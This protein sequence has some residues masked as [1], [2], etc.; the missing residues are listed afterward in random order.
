MNCQACGSANPDDAYFC[1]SCGAQMRSAMERGSGPVDLAAIGAQDP[2]LLGPATAGSDGG[3]TFT[4]PA[5][6]DYSDVAGTIAAPPG[7]QPAAPIEPEAA[8]P[9]AGGYAP[10]PQAGFA[11][12][13]G[14]YAAPHYPPAQYGQPQ[15]GQPAQYG[16]PYAPPPYGLPADGNTS[17]MG[18][19][20]PLPLEANGWTFAG[21]IPYG[22]FAFL[23]GNTTW[24]VIG[25]L[26][27]IFG[28]HI[29]YVIYIGIKGREMAWQ[30]R[31][32]ESAM[33]FSDTMREWNKWGLIVLIVAGVAILLYFLLVFG[34]IFMAASTEGFQ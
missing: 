5:E 26:L 17:G 23:N 34:L 24:G 8:G 22:L 3:I 19:G 15:Y 10:P 2:N 11:P 27:S 28:L 4:V 6:A 33:Q 25:L 32:F 9:P 31:R 12:P 30:G 20:Y 18:P 13:P 29:V 14:Q 16:A 7:T 1:G 21:F